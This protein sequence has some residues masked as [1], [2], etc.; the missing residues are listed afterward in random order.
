[1]ASPLQG[2]KRIQQEFYCHIQEVHFIFPVFPSCCSGV[3]VAH[4]EIAFSLSAIFP[5]L[6]LDFQPFR[7]FQS[8]HALTVNNGDLD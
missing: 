2:K 8:E 1:M 4:A 7:E 5:V 6:L 3:L